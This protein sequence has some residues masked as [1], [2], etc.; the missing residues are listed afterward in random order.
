M[1]CPSESETRAP[2]SRCSE[3]VLTKA[4]LAPLL[5]AAAALAFWVGPTW[6][7]DQTVH[8][9]LGNGARAVE[10][11]SVRYAPS[12]SPEDWTRE[13]TFRYPRGAAPRIVTHAPRLPDGEYLVEIDVASESAR[14]QT[15][16]QVR[17][18]GGASSIDVSDGAVAT[19]RDH[20]DAASP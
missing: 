4:R 15:R 8:L 1:P 14:S 9:V 10:E 2:A 12:A 6:P 17:L 18:G 19:R 20:R 7:K 13:V 3:S 16:R 11:V 5:L